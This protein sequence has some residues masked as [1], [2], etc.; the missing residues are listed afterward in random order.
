MLSS[1]PKRLEPGVGGG[2]CSLW[3][4]LPS[5]PV[6][7]LEAVS[8]K[9]PNKSLVKQLQVSSGARALQG[10]AGSPV[11]AGWGAAGRHRALRSTGTLRTCPQ[12]ADPPRLT[13]RARASALGSA[14]RQLH[15]SPW[16]VWPQSNV[17][18]SALG[19]CELVLNLNFGLVLIAHLTME[20]VF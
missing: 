3:G 15:T 17:E 7:L 20:R 6:A 10:T 9:S 1:R 2:V 16:R 8:P 12:Y 19:G 5:A 4:G 13:Q 14:P 18:R 11:G